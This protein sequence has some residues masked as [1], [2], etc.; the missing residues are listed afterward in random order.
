MDIK[1]RIVLSENLTGVAVRNFLTANGYPNTD[2]RYFTNAI[3]TCTRG[4]D[5]V[6]TYRLDL[7]SRA[8]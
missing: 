6:S 2:G 5:L 7:A 3:D 4:I 8:A 1:D